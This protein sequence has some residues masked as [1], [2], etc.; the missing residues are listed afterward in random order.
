[1]VSHLRVALFVAF[2][3]VVRQGALAKLLYFLTSLG[4]PA[5]MV[6]FVLSGYFISASV[7]RSAR[8]PSGFW[9]TYL[10]NRLT[11]L[12]VVLLPALL[13]VAFWDHLGM[14]L[15]GHTGVYG[16][17]PEDRYILPF[18]TAGRESI[19]IFLLNLL[20]LQSVWATGVA[21][22]FGTDSPLWS[23][24]NEFWYYIAFPLF[25][26]AALSSAGVRRRWIYLLMG[27]CVLC[28]VGKDIALYFPVW[29]L[30]T[31][32]LYVP[33]PASIRRF[34]ARWVGLGAV[35]LAV[36]LAIQSK[37]EY[38]SCIDY[39][40][41]LLFA[42]WV[43]LILAVVPSG[44]A[45]TDAPPRAVPRKRR[46]VAD[47]MAAFSYTLYLTHLPLLILVH[48]WLYSRNP[49]K[50]QPDPKHVALAAIIAIGLLGYAW[51]VS[52]LTEAQTDRVRRIVQ[53]MFVPR[54]RVTERQ[55]AAPL[56]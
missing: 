14:H 16:G 23:L 17:L 13:L 21:P 27:I 11:R 38:I 19:R 4:H 42:A 41:G 36:V 40:S 3:E 31:A 52:L 34:P 29:L 32:L 51:L 10:I 2:P 39:I 28:F 18:S 35:P 55:T 44:S 1:M 8:R 22:T 54:S 25:Y 20:F 47:S 6:F 5:V 53:G 9:G 12:L 15:F 30:G 37:H 33:R 43:Y 24:A 48:A 56:V 50:W 7:V 26:F 45:P 49:T 46:T